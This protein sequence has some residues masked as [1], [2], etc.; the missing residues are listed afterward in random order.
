[1]TVSLYSRVMPSFLLN[2]LMAISLVAVTVR[3]V[4]ENGMKS[5]VSVV[6]ITYVK[7]YFHVKC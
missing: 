2:S 4:V 7:A 6:I 1:M 5:D 3:S